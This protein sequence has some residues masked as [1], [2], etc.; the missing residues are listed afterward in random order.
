M[1]RHNKIVLSAIFTTALN[2]LVIAL[3]PCE[4]VKSPTV[5]VKEYR[6]LTPTE[7]DLLQTKLPPAARLLV[8]TAIDSGLRWGE[9]TELRPSDANLSSSVLTVSRAVVE[10]QPQFHPSGGRF[11]V[12]PYPKGKRSRR[13]K[14]NAVLVLEL[15]DHATTHGLGPDDLPFSYDLL[16][17]DAPGLAPLASVDT[18]GLTEPNGRGRSYQHGTLS[19]YTARRCRC[20]HCRGAFATYRSG[21]RAVGLDDPRGRREPDT[22]GHIPRDWFRRNIWTPACEAAAI[23]PPVRIH[24]LRHA[25]ASWLLAGGADLQVV[26]ERLGHRSIA[27][28]EKYLHTLPEADETALAAMDRIRKRGKPRA[29]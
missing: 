1:I 3:H 17:N 27:T 4:G 16:S 2:D 19:A 24:E 22:D 29:G 13:F 14:L 21:R 12:K 10:L 5:P 11:L 7:Y 23:D 28:S 25:N 15:K 9:L 6:I 8:E 26:K 20:P 18:L